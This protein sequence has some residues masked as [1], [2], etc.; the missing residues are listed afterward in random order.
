M[1]SGQSATSFYL[2]ALFRS[3]TF[4][5]LGDGEWLQRFASRRGEDDET[6]EL[7]FATLVARHGA[8]VLRV[9]RAV[10]GDRHETEDAFQATFLVLARR[11]GSIRRGG[12]VGSWLHGV[13]LRV[14]ARARSRAAQRQRHQRR[15]AAVKVS[16]TESLFLRGKGVRNRISAFWDCL[17]DRE[18]IP[19]PC[20]AR[21]VRSTG[22]GN[23]DAPS[24]Q[25]LCHAG[26]ASECFGGSGRTPA[27]RYL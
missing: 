23:R 27:A 7:A 20:D 13:A 24:I 14:A 26:S 21:P 15:R 11:A 6:A 1:A 25:N 12:S 9:C 16:G 22:Q 10:L 2:S 17:E 3:G 5:G 8:M 4:A 18:S 19:R